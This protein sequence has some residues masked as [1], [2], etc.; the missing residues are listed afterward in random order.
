MPARGG[1]LLLRVPS[2]RPE[3][4]GARSSA[5]GF[6]VFF[7]KGATMAGTHAPFVLV[8]LVLRLRGGM[9][10]F[11]V[12]FCPW[13][14][15]GDWFGRVNVADAVQ[16]YH[17]FPETATA[18]KAQYFWRAVLSGIPQDGHCCED[19]MHLACSPIRHSSRRTLL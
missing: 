4:R 17:A 16:S 5:S 3:R 19:S 1:L 7:E 18:V 9:Q 11:V 2:T 8:A 15:A 14:R 13:L 6:V 10:I 12:A